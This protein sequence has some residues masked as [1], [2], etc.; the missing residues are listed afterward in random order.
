MGFGFF[1][2]PSK[3]SH[4]LYF[5]YKDFSSIKLSGIKTRLSYMSLAINTASKESHDLA[6]AVATWLREVIVNELSVT[7][8]KYFPDKGG[9]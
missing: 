8:C 7:C 1:T 5:Q 4:T 6:I 3:F 2:Q 9:L